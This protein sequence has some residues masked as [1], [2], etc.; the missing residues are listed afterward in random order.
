MKTITLT[1]TEFYTFKDLAQ[2]FKFIFTC[3]VASGFVI[4]EADAQILEYLGF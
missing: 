1:P 2:K 4:V 3:T